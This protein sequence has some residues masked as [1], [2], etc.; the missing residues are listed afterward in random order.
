MQAALVII[1]TLGSET[2]IAVGEILRE[3]DACV[4]ATPE[5]DFGAPP[6][7]ISDNDTHQKAAAATPDEL[8]RWAG[9]LATL[10]GV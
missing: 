7:L 9:A 1:W 6:A 10:R 5:Y 8:V 3:A 4:F 2:R